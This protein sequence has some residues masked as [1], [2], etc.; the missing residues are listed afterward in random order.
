M[1]TKQRL[2][3]AL[4]EQQGFVTLLDAVALINRR[5]GY[6]SGRVELLREL[7]RE[8]RPDP[9]VNGGETDVAGVDGG[10]ADLA[11]DEEEAEG[12]AER[13]RQWAPN[14]LKKGE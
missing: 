10:V 3:E 5:M 7:V 12:D 1:K 8:T 9:P 6:Y 14:S 4:A 13:G 2:Q 11:V